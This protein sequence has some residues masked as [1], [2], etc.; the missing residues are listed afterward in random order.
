M[1]SGLPCCLSPPFL[2]SP[3]MSPRQEPWEVP[4]CIFLF[5]ATKKKRLHTSLYSIDTQSHAYGFTNNTTHLLISTGFWDLQTKKNN[6]YW[7]THQGSHHWYKLKKKKHITSITE[8]AQHNSHSRLP[9]SFYNTSTSNISITNHTRWVY[10]E[11]KLTTVGKTY[12]VAQDPLFYFSHLAVYN[13]KRK[14]ILFPLYNT[15]H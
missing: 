14:E 8:I 1:T 10:A 9:L 4:L 7:S 3:Q 13:K 2:L 5:L 15:P 11:Q 12:Q 6:T